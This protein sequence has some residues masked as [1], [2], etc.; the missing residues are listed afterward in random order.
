MNKIKSLKTIY[1][2]ILIAL[3]SDFAN[4]AQ[5]T[6]ELACIKE[7]ENF[8]VKS[9]ETEIF[10]RKYDTCKSDYEK[11]FAQLPIDA[12]NDEFNLVDQYRKRLIVVDIKIRPEIIEARNRNLISERIAKE[13][14]EKKAKL[15]D[16][17]K[18]RLAYQLFVEKW[19]KELKPGV[20]YKTSNDQGLIIELNQKTG[21]AKVQY[22][23]CASTGTNVSGG[24][25]YVPIM[26]FAYCASYATAEK[27]IPISELYPPNN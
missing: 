18:Q 27:H 15:E 4:S 10:N 17:K 8:P 6:S 1:P 5:Y 13:D 23:Y 7:L 12:S 25:R 22:E 20:R 16:E 19:R 14:A 9:G 3:V 26:S 11:I 2:F 24:T 21:L